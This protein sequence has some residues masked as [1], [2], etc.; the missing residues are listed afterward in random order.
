MEVLYGAT[1]VV[2][3]LR[4]GRRHVLQTLY[5]NKDMM[6]VSRKT[7]QH[8]QQ[9]LK[10]AEKRNVNMSFVSKRKLE[11]LIGRNKVHQGLCLECSPIPITT[12]EPNNEQLCEK[13]KRS[14]IV[15]IAADHVQ[16]PVNLGTIFRAAMFF[17]CSGILLS[18]GCAPL[19]PTVS[20]Y[21]AGAME[22]LQ[23]YE[24]DNL[25]SS[26]KDAVEAN[27][28]VLGATSNKTP[29]V[30][31]SSKLSYRKRS[32]L[33]VGNEGRGLSP[34]VVKVCTSLVNIPS[35]KEG[36]WE[37][38]LNVAVATSCLLLLLKA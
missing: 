3:A 26:L 9:A 8:V 35:S 30:I 6:S 4:A 19:S 22:Y 31:S 37:P 2:H 13:G 11:V 21:S 24:T 14:R 20:K 16:D 7:P 5:I 23:A 34:R 33:T 17:E 36:L 12:W 18:R 32:I 10:E 15:V 1:P 27:W 28:D 25:S 29:Q 38:S